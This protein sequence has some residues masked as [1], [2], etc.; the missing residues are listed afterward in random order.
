MTSSMS[1]FGP[2]TP[3]CSWTSRHCVAPGERSAAHASAPTS[4]GGC[5]PIAAAVVRRLGKRSLR[6]PVTPTSMSLPPRARSGD[7]SRGWPPTCRSRLYLSRLLLSAFPFGEGYVA[8][9]ANEPAWRR[10]SGSCVLLAMKVVQIRLNLCRLASLALSL[11]RASAEL[12]SGQSPRCS[13]NPV[14]KGGGHGA[15]PGEGCRRYRG[16]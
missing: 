15:D 12:A 5:L 14:D 11:S 1:G 3:L 13:S 16:R 4:G 7:S 9:L 10:E 6:M 2:L 8:R